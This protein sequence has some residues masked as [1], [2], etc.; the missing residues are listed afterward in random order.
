MSFVR[1]PFKLLAVESVPDDSLAIV[2]SSVV[3]LLWRKGQEMF[4]SEHEGEPSL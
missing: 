1:V 2:A 4:H 3:E